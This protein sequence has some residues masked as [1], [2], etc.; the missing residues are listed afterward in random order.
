MDNDFSKQAINE[1]M[2]LEEA[3]E[4]W[5]KSTDSLR[6]ACIERQGRPPR[7]KVGIEARRSKRIWLVTRT[8]M[9]RLY[10]PAPKE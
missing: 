9:E 2:T 6:Q 7:F 10:G 1:V 5:G 4:L 8:G 3:A